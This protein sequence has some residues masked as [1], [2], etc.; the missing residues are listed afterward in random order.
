MGRCGGCALLARWF[1]FPMRAD[2]VLDSFFNRK[3]LQEYILLAGQHPA[4]GLRDKPPKCVLF[5]AP[6]HSYL[7]SY[8][9]QE[10]GCLP[11]R[12]LYLR[13]VGCTTSCVSFARTARGGAR[14]MERGRW[15]A[16]DC[17]CGVA[18]LDGGRRW[19]ICC[20]LGCEPNSKLIPASSMIRSLR[21]FQ[22]ATHPLFNL[23]VT[24]AEGIMAHFYKQSVP[25]RLP[26][27][28]S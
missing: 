3:A 2:Y 21:K 12:V 17:L 10:S 5:S 20:R 6:F 9:M 27:P 14:G 19:L 1:V 28:S 25:K 4:G 8:G 24:H 26:K 11:Y 22:N 15:G 23:T 18:L 16:G 7:C 13:L